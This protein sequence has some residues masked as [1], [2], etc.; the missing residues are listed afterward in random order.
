MLFNLSKLSVTLSKLGE[1]IIQ[2][3]QVFAIP[4]INIK[5]KCF[6]VQEVSKVFTILPFVNAFTQEAS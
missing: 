6:G 5:H 1:V 3:L 4:E 2:D